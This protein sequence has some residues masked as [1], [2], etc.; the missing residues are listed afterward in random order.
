MVVQ[1]RRPISLSCEGHEPVT[2]HTPEQEGREDRVTV[3]HTR[4]NGNSN[5]YISTLTITTTVY[6]DTGKT[7]IDVFTKYTRLPFQAPTSA[8][9]RTP[10]T[11]W[12]L[13]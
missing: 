1:A 6:K 9:S 7:G 4:N 13:T 2:W 12:P 11:C 3:A 5:K 8:V 10:Q